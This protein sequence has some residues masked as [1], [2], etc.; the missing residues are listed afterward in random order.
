MKFLAPS[1]WFQELFDT[2][3]Y[4]TPLGIM[5]LIVSNVMGKNAGQL[6]R[7]IARYGTA[8]GIPRANTPESIGTPEL[9]EN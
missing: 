8:R 6:E 4:S 7:W 1:G 3:L 2:P 5:S 9:A